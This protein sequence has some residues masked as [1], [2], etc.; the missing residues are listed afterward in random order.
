MAMSGSYEFLAQ[1]RVIFGWPA[2]EAVR[3]TTDKFGKHRLMIVAS[4]TLSRKTDVV[5]AGHLTQYCSFK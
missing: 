3:E 5:R 1:D 2:N 4:K